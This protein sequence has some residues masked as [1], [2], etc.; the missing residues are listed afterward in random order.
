MSKQ[1]SSGNRGGEGSNASLATARYMELKGEEIDKI[2]GDAFRQVKDKIEKKRFVW[3]R[4]S[5]QGS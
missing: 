5:L 2:V 4:G 3:R 1:S